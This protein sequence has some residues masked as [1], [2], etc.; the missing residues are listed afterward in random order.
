MITAETL[1]SHLMWDESRWV[2]YSGAFGVEL[3]RE[4]WG[5]TGVRYRLLS[6]VDLGTFPSIGNQSPRRMTYGIFEF[7]DEKEEEVLARGA[8][9][10]NSLDLESIRGLAPGVEKLGQKRQKRLSALERLI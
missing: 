3:T 5:S 10:L 6:W 9:V 2:F 8:E 4:N 7:T 1:Q